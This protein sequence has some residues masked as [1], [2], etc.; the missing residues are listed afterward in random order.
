VRQA[1]SARDT[2]RTWRR[3]IQVMAP[4]SSTKP[5]TMAMGKLRYHGTTR[6][7]AMSSRYESAK[8]GAMLMR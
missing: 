6:S 5:A 8:V 7:R 2:S 1:A 3:S 4:I